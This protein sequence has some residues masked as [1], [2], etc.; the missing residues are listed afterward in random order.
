MNAQVTRSFSKLFDL[1]IGVE[2]LFHFKQNDPII[3]PA[4]PNGQYFDASLIWG[5]ITG[6]MLYAGLRYK[7]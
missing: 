7:L 4:N 2:N 5:P 1:Y 3:D 6:R